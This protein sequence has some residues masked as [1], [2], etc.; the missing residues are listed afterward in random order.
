MPT[1]AYARTLSSKAKQTANLLSKSLS[2]VSASD[3]AADC[4]NVRTAGYAA[5][6]DL[7]G[8]L[9]K[10]VGS[11]PSHAGKFQSADGAWWELA[12][13]VVTPQMFGALTIGDATA[14]IQAAIDWCYNDGAIRGA[15]HL[16]ANCTFTVSDPNGDGYCLLLPDGVNM[17]GGSAFTSI[18]RTTTAGKVILR[19]HR[20][21]T[22][23]QGF[24][25][26]FGLDGTSV[27]K[28]CLELFG[29][30]YD[31]SGGT[32]RC[33]NA[34]RPVVI[35]GVQN[36]TLRSCFALN[37]D[38]LYS[39]LNGAGTVELDV[40]YG[41]YGRYGHILIDNDPAYE[42]YQLA[43]AGSVNPL[44]YV[45]PTAI[46]VRG[47]VYEDDSQTFPGEAKASVRINTGSRVL[48]YGNATLALRPAGSETF[49]DDGR[50]SLAATQASGTSFTVPLAD[51][52][53][54]F[55]VGRRVLM[56]AA[57]FGHYAMPYGSPEY[58]SATTFQVSGNQTSVFA[59]GT[60]VRLVKRDGTAVSAT[61]SSS[62]FSTNTTVTV[63]TSVVPTDMISAQVGLVYGVVSSTSF[64]TNTTVNLTMD[65]G[66]TVPATLA[67]VEIGRS[68]DGAS[69][70]WYPVV[71][72]THIRDVT[73]A[74]AGPGVFSN[75]ALRTGSDQ[76]IYDGFTL[77]GLG[78]DW[79]EISKNAS[80]IKPNGTLAGGKLRVRHIRGIFAGFGAISYT[81]TQQSNA[82][83]FELPGHASTMVYSSSGNAWRFVDTVGNWRIL[84]VVSSGT[85]APTFSATH[86]GQQFIDTTLAKAYVAY[87]T[88]NGVGDWMLLN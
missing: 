65:A 54:Y 83:T 13:T 44:A 30:A 45:T 69:S 59:G 58:L 1:D 40:C 77:S 21:G 62:A 17:F 26:D 70:F 31:A 75:S 42:G 25:R 81:A 86:V 49:I 56:M 7:G 72:G 36:F 61:V 23:R 46:T 28:G 4:N 51:L 74:N 20:T 32:I 33:Q 41:R 76:P 55:P 47:G 6:G 15:L 67:N 37:G 48:I 2:T 14:A 11:A 38:W 34:Q 68:D 60:R 5:E 57:S 53:A 10:R 18:I 27:A 80:V 87:R 12:E 43:P 39:I 3:I 64:A 52:T 9:Y 19:R 85:A 88:G 29:S 71:A 24:L 66:W 8:A 84:P 79:F 82:G 78:G 63:S 22:A 50:F 73:L 16:P 35:D